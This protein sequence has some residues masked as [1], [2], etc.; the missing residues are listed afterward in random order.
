[1][2]ILLSVSIN[3][4]FL[5]DGLVGYYN[6]DGDSND[7]LGIYNGT[8]TSITY[9]TESILGLSANFSSS[10]EIHLGNFSKYFDDAMTVCLWYYNNDT[11]NAYAVHTL[12]D[13]FNEPYFQVGRQ[14][15][16][17]RTFWSD[18]PTDTTYSNILT[19]DI[20]ESWNHTCVVFNN[21]RHDVY[22]DGSYVTGND[23]AP[24]ISKNWTFNI[25]MGAYPGSI[26][27]GLI[28]ELAIYNTTLTEVEISSLYNNGLGFNPFTSF[29]NLTLS[30][31]ELSPLNDSNIYVNGTISYGLTFVNGTANCT[32]YN[33][34][35]EVDKMIDLD[36]ATHTFGY[37]SSFWIQGYNKVNITCNDYKNVESQFKYLFVDEIQ[38][39]I[40]YI[41][42]TTGGLSS[43]LDMARIIFWDFDVQILTNDTNNY[44][45]NIT[46]SKN[47]TGEIVYGY[48][49]TGITPEYLLTH[50]IPFD[51]DDAGVY[52][53]S[54]TAKDAHTKKILDF[55]SQL[56]DKDYKTLTKIGKKFDN[57]IT[58]YSEKKN[59]KNFNLIEK[60]DRKEFDIEFKSSVT[61][62]S[63]YVEGN[64]KVDYV[65][66]RYGYL[67]HFIIDNIYWY[68]LENNG[69]ATILSV[70]RLNHKLYKVNM[71]KPEDVDRIIFHSV[72]LMN[73]NNQNVTFTYA[74]AETILNITILDS[75]TLNKINY[76]NITVQ[77]IT[78]STTNQVITDNGTL[79]ELI[80]FNTTGLHNVSVRA[81]ETYHDDYTI[82][83]RDIEIEFGLN[84]TLS[85]YMTNTSDTTKTQLTQMTVEDISTG[86]KV[87]NAIIH[88][89]KQVPSTGGLI[90]ISDLTTNSNG[91]ASTILEIDTVFYQFIVEYQGQTVYSSALFPITSDSTELFFP[92][93]LSEE[94]LEYYNTLFNIDHTLSYINVTDTSGYFKIQYTSSV[95]FDICMDVNIENSTGSFNQEQ[96]CQTNVTTGSL[97][98]ST[99]S[100]TNYT[101]YRGVVIVDFNDGNGYRFLDS[102]SVYIGDDS[103]VKVGVEG[104]IFVILAI[105]ISVFGFMYSP[106]AGLLVFMLSFTAVFMFKLSS[107]TGVG[108]LISPIVYGL[109]MVICIFTLITISKRK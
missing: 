79:I 27:T 99:H 19:G 6:F 24:Y 87:E 77:M 7:T 74:P 82:V 60:V 92:V 52:N 50:N 45:I 104:V 43:A 91:Q 84:N 13:G 21:T 88:I 30:F 51:L 105:V 63:M 23:K 17:I 18:Y 95:N 47:D 3:A 44:L 71:E 94:A 40:H 1:M 90:E 76:T 103:K 16:N 97:N 73:A 5:Q 37:N 39:D 20:T 93:D 59:V 101:L 10:S 38:P 98:S 70:E 53:M 81:F 29:R 15:N 11:N 58:T 78:S 107:V 28:D 64:T 8:D 61:T 85:L 80:D 96:V 62:F 54:V 75:N 36:N 42:Y 2:L 33:N 55:K 26:W 49:E 68:D 100:Q 106:I 57:T 46:I 67:G 72:G 35:V 4:I 83:I 109:V 102:L 89:Y 48:E 69:D 86:N 66:D 108:T 22:I 32:L 31:E 12:G 25:S 34:D 56:I 65:G 14:N 41:N 9:E